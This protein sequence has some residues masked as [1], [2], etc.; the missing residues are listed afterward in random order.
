MTVT[1]YSYTTQWVDDFIRHNFPQWEYLFP[2]IPDFSGSG[3]AQPPSDP[4]Q[5]QIKVSLPAPEVLDPAKAGLPAF[6]PI[7]PKEINPK[8]L[9]TLKATLQ[10]FGVDKN[11]ANM[12]S[13]TGQIIKRYNYLA[14]AVDVGRLINEFWNIWSEDENALIHNP[15]ILEALLPLESTVVTYPH[16]WPDALPKTIDIPEFEGLPIPVKLP[17]FDMPLTVEPTSPSKIDFNFNFDTIDFSPKIRP[18]ILPNPLIEIGSPFLLPDR[19][20]APS[21]R[22][23]PW[24]PKPDILIP[25]YMPGINIPDP[26][27]NYKPY[28]ETL[29][30]VRMELNV[31][32]LDAP[33]LQIQVAKALELDPVRP[34][35]N[36]LRKDN[37][38][39]SKS[40]YIYTMQ[41]ISKT[42]GK[43]SEVMD[44]YNALIWNMWVKPSKPM[45]ILVPS[46][47]HGE[48]TY[49]VVYLD[50]AQRVGSLPMNAQKEVLKLIATQRIN[51]EV[52]WEGLQRD[53]IKMEL[54]D[55]TIA[56][57]TKL[58]RKIIK[59]SIDTPLLD[60]GNLSTWFRRAERTYPKQ[61]E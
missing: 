7:I 37:K 61:E 52:N 18:I 12:A 50:S 29:P 45:N 59:S 20:G 38:D 25:P 17:N 9:A 28:L 21:P 22:Y 41:F 54:D 31:G 56:G 48:N 3:T 27:P 35:Q 24:Q 42:F 57:R 47:K 11:A 36:R 40:K 39:S 44:F 30:Q 60:F 55:A 6:A 15:E 16:S 1:G 10:T 46:F 53:I 2:K 43:V 14:I 58:E 23:Y 32:T 33:K 5:E 19:K 4:E 49:Y 13:F 51:V 26:L 8:S 34:E